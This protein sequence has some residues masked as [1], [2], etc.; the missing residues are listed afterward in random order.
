MTGTRYPDM[1]CLSMLDGEERDGGRNGGRPGCPSRNELPTLEP[2][3]PVVVLEY[4]DPEIGAM[5]RMACGLDRTD[6]KSATAF[7]IGE[8]LGEDEPM[9]IGRYLDTIKGRLNVR[10][11]GNHGRP[12]SKLIGR[13]SAMSAEQK[14]KAAELYHGGKTMQEV[15]DEL[16]ATLGQVRY[17][18]TKT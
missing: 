13:P 8:E 5:V 16:G 9:K 2:E 1:V 14:A 18:L 4:S 17:V 15:A 7:E 10:E 6:G 11:S 12:R 3:R